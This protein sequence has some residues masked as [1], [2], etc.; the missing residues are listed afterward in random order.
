MAN[1]N[2]MSQKDRVASLLTR[3]FKLTSTQIANRLRTSPNRARFVISDLRNAG[4]D[5]VT[6]RKVSKNGTVTNTYSLYN[7]TSSY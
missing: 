5:I 1:T 6:D 7:G 4:Y 3:G 2:K